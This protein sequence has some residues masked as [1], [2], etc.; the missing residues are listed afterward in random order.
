MK[1]KSVDIDLLLSALLLFSV[2]IG[3]LYSSRLMAE[4]ASTTQA[5]AARQQNLR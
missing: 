3:L 2:L 5:S 1:H 4:A